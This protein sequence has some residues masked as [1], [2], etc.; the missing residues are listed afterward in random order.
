VQSTISL[1]LY[2]TRGEE[3]LSRRFDRLSFA[4]IF[5]CYIVFN[6]AIALASDA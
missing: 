4:I 6:I 3:A 5:F 1:H 2:A